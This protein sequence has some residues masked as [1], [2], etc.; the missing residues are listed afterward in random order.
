VKSEVAGVDEDGRYCTRQETASAPDSNFD[1]LLQ[2][3]QGKWFKSKSLQKQKHHSIKKRRLKIFSRKLNPL[4]VSFRLPFCSQ[5]S[6]IDI[7]LSKY[8]LKHS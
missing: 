4:R 5:L 3:A 1:G 2:L 6:I 8:Y 7:I